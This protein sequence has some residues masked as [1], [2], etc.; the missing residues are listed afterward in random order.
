MKTKN[1]IKTAITAITFTFVTLMVASGL[2]FN[3]IVGSDNFLCP[4]DPFICIWDS[5]YT[6]VTPG[7]HVHLHEALENGGTCG[8]FHSE[9]D[10]DW[11][12][13]SNWLCQDLGEGPYT[14]WWSQ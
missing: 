13:T 4:F 2:K 14:H 1:I 9:A 11:A 12:W 3:F 8:T 5:Y 7:T 6:I 10:R